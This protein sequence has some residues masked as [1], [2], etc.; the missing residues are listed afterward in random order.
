MLMRALR[1]E[2]SCTWETRLKE[3]NMWA[4]TYSAGGCVCV[5][6]CVCMLVSQLCPTLQ[7]H[8]LLPTWLL[9]PWDSPG[10]NTDEVVI[11]FSRGCS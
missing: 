7:P 8:G 10:K 2:N 1:Q 3:K 4:E 9:Y 6:V 11:P 5:C